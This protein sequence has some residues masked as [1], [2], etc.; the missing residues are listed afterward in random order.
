VVDVY[1]VEELMLYA[2]SSEKTP[3]LS[4]ALC[5]SALFAWLSASFKR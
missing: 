4:V 2:V 1:T 3:N 5:I